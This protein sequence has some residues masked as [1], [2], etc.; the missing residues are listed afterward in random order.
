MIY[1]K[2]SLNALWVLMGVNLLVFI[3]TTIDRDLVYTFGLVPATVFTR[4]WTLLTSIFV[5]GSL[6]HIL[7]NML[8]LYFFGSFLVRFLGPSRFLI[9]Y[10]VAGIV[11]SV[12]YSFLAP[13]YSLAVGASGAIFGL[14]GIMTVMTPK[15]RVFVFPIPVPIPLWAAIIG[16]FLILSLFPGI[17]WEAH[18]GGLLCGLVMGYFLRRDVRR[19]QPRPA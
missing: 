8:T 6:W 9:A 7:T 11:G 19:S 5:H 10:F 4:P 2:R 14:G 3:V 17:A 12:L 1:R 16:G 15:L 13:A 18:L